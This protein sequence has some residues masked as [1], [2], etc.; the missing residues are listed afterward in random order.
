MTYLLT[1]VLPTWEHLTTRLVTSGIDL[2][3]RDAMQHFMSTDTH[4]VNRMKTRWTRSE[5]ACVRE[6]FVHVTTRTL[7]AWSVAHRRTCA[8]RERGKKL[9]CTTSTFQRL[10]NDMDTRRAWSSVTDV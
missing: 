2:E 9:C 7:G 8:T 3:T 4:S 5:V 6:M 10:Q 1:F